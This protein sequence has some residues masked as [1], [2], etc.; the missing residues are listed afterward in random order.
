MAISVPDE[1]VYYYDESQEKEPVLLCWFPKKVLEKEILKNNVDSQI[2][3]DYPDGLD[4]EVNLEEF[5]LFNNKYGLRFDYDPDE[6]VL[7]F[8]ALQSSKKVET[9]K[10]IQA[11]ALERVIKE[12]KSKDFANKIRIKLE[13]RQLP[14]LRQIEVIEKLPFSPSTAQVKAELHRSRTVQRDFDDRLLDAKKKIG[15]IPP[16][17]GAPPEKRLFGKTKMTKGEAPLAVFY[18]IQQK[19]G[20]S[21]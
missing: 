18:R 2:L 10:V 8:E 15:F 9:D 12:T 3:V 17:E 16:E 20:G 4:L 21:K 7:T 19:S 5:D 11:E 6:I 1:R 13:S 14:E